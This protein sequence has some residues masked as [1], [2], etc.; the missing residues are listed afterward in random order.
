MDTPSW[1]SLW[2]GFVSERSCRNHACRTTAEQQ[3][4]TLLTSC[5]VQHKLIGNY[6]PQTPRKIDFGSKLEAKIGPKNEAILASPNE[7]I[8]AVSRN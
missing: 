3:Q 7:T 4:L 1:S 2:Q 6:L 8:E 5:R